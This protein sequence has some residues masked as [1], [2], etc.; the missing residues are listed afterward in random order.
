[1]ARV[2]RTGLGLGWAG[3][4]LRTYLAELLAGSLSWVRE[5]AGRRLI[6]KQNKERADKT[7][8]TRA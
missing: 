5:N 7:W 6:N 1:M 2:E 3:L 4:G 8:Q